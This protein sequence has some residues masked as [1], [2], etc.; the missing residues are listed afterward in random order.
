MVKPHTW[1]VF[2]EACNC[3]RRGDLGLHVAEGR[4]GAACPLCSQLN[5]AVSELTGQNR[6]LALQKRWGRQG[7]TCSPDCD[8]LSIQPREIA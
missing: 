4:Q 8:R 6:P 5:T 3:Y 7:Q 1:Q 2:L